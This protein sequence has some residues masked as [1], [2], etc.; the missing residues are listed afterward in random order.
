MLTPGAIPAKIDFSTPAATEFAQLAK[1]YIALKGA[2][3]PPNYQDY[4]QT[5]NPNLKVVFLDQLV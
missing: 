2:S 5:K 1:D 3:S 4:K